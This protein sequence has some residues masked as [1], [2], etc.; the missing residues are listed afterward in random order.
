MSMP[1]KQSQF[2]HS[3]PRWYMNYEKCEGLLFGT[4]RIAIWYI[5]LARTAV[6]NFKTVTKGTKAGRRGTSRNPM[7][8]LGISNPDSPLATE[9]QPRMD[10]G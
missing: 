8:I 5:H 1:N 7:T 4:W 3:S 10:N 6:A 2:S 9:S